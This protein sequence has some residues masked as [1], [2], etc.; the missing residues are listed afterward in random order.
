MLTVTA[1]GEA[2]VSTPAPVDTSKIKGLS[3]K[4]LFG[5]QSRLYQ[6]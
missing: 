4:P 2:K 5:R 1:Q 3:G 6:C